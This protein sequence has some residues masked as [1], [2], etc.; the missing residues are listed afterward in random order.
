MSGADKFLKE[1][2]RATKAMEA[3]TQDKEFLDIIAKEVVDIIKKRTRLGYSVD[4]QGGSKQK[5]NPLS[6]KYVEHRQKTGVS[7]PGTPARSNLT[8]TGQMLD[9]LTAEVFDRFIT[10]KFDSDES[11]TKAMY[12]T[13]QGRPFMNLSQSEI[14]QVRQL[15]QEHLR[16]RFE[17]LV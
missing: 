6:K 7:G 5:L 10:F 14:N 16:M 9:D 12:V 2:T 13:E 11:E 3:L 8:Y 15:I 4:S 17:R 1:I